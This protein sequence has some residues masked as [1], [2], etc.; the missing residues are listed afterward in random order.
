[1]RI[2]KLSA[3]QRR[4]GRVLVHLDSGDILRVGE[5]EVVSQ[6]LY[7]GM[8]LDGAA[9]AALE[10]AA[11][12]RQVRE[13][14]MDLLSL[15]PMSRRELIGKLT[16]K[17][18]DLQAAED[19]AGWLEGLG[20]LDDES[21]ARALVRHYAGK[22]YGPYR[23][24]QELYRRGVPRAFWEAAAEEAPS[25]EKGI[26]GFLGKK[27]LPEELED[28]KVRKKASDALARRGY[29]W[30]DISAGLRTYCGAGL[31]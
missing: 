14:A 11:R 6:G 28:P 26:L 16:A 10:D 24:E 13:R 21:Y 2:S 23:I 30:E 1:M 12:R 8:E 18:A 27:W 25:P 19:A 5:S 22:G 3:S 15:R 20:L 17:G 9:L 4:E 29:R 7:A 31:E